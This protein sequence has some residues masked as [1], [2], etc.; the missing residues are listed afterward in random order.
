MSRVALALPV[1]VLQ[2]ASLRQTD[3]AG[4]SKH[5]LSSRVSTDSVVLSGGDLLADVL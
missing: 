3:S 5:V 1:L 2:L 4:I